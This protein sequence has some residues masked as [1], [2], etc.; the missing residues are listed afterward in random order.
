EMQMIFQDPYAS[1]NPRMTIG[2]TLAEPLDIH[3]LVDGP[4][5]RR[6]RIQSLLAKVGLRPDAVSRYPHAFSG[7]QRQRARPARPLAVEPKVIVGGAPISALDVSIQAEL[8][9]LLQDLQKADNLAYL[10]ICRGLRIVQHIRDRVA[11]M[12]LGKVVA[13]AAA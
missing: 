7:G 1:L 8:V 10:F 6:E 4:D 2:A 13:L 3:K 9:N 11:V 5:A 12:Y